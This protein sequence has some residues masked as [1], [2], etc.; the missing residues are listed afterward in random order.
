MHTGLIS[1]NP[2][3]GINH[4]PWY[5]RCIVPRVLVPRGCW[6]KSFLIQWSP[7]HRGTPP[8]CACFDGAMMKAQVDARKAP[9]PGL[10]R[11]H[12]LRFPISTGVEVCSLAAGHSGSVLTKLCLFPGLQG[13][14]GKPG[15]RGETNKK[16]PLSRTPKPLSSTFVSSTQWGYISLLRERNGRRKHVFFSFFKKQGLR[17]TKLLLF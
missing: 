5:P 2:C 16:A 9:L 10:P 11:T 17:I 4:Q 7:E 6:R 8:D 12:L 15:S 14:Q 3:H 13:S 1:T